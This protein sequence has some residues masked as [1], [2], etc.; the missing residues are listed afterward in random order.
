L[1]GLPRPRA[2][3]VGAINAKLDL[4]LFIELAQ[5]LPR[6]TVVLVGPVE[7]AKGDSRLQTLRNM[8]NVHFLGK[9]PVEAVPHYIK[10]LDVCLLPYE[11]N[12][13]TRHIS[14][15]KLYEYLACGKPV[16]SS[17]VPAAR[18]QGELVAIAQNVEQFVSLVEGAL[19]DN[20]E[21][22]VK[23]R[24]QVASQNTWRHR[25]ERIS[26]LIEAT[27]QA[28]GTSCGWEGGTSGD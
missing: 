7:C 2:G 6:W 28:K 12:E 27:L 9:K 20:S 24:R 3:Y 13:W 4:T 21:D 26:A 5:R 25:V 18:E 19:Y 17:D 23:R 11:R 22:M 14:S 8:P 1:A 15:L 10:G 16:V